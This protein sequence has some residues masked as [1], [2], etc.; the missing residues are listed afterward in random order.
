[1]NIHKFRLTLKYDQNLLVLGIIMLNM[2][3]NIFSSQALKELGT[4]FDKDCSCWQLLVCLNS[5]KI[6]HS[7]KILY[8]YLNMRNVT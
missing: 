8:F 1:M 5:I 3:T 6:F 2:K 7:T 4:I